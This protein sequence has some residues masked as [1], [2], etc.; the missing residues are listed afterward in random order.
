MIPP[1]DCRPGR[2]SAISRWLSVS[3]AT[4]TEFVD[5]NRS[6][7]DRTLPGNDII[8]TTSKRRMSLESLQ[9]S[10]IVDA[11]DSGGVAFAQPP[12]NRCNASGI[13]RNGN[14]AFTWARIP[15][16]LVTD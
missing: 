9:D 16:H 5:S 6:Q 2:T 10:K 13:R 12:A 11:I 4:G 15:S 14:F 1:L 8:G 7:R 3:D